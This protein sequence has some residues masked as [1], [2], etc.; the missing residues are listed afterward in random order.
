[1]LFLGS[2]LS[3]V[4]AC[5]GNQAS[6]RSIVS[7]FMKQFYPC[8]PEKDDAMA[9]NLALG[10]K[11]PGGY[12]K[13]K[14]MN[15]EVGEYPK[16]VKYFH[17][18]II[19]QIKENERGTVIQAI[20]LLIR[21]DRQI[22][23]DTVIDI[24]SETKKKD[25]FFC[26]ERIDS[27]LTGVFLYTLKN[28]S[29]KQE[30]GLAKKI[31]KK[32]V[33]RA[34][35]EELP[36]YQRKENKVL[37]KSLMD[38]SSI[39]LFNEEHFSSAGVAILLQGWNENNRFD[40][41]FIEILAGKNCL[42]IYEDLHTQNTINVSCENGIVRCV[43]ETQLRSKM[44]ENIDESHLRFL[45][46]AVYESMMKASIIDTEKS[47]T[48]N[49]TCAFL[50]FFGFNVMISN[51]IE[52]G[53]WDNIFF[54]FLSDILKEKRTIER[55]SPNLTTLV[56][57][58]PDVFLD[59]FEY[60]I[61]EPEYV[62]LDCLK[63]T[64]EKKI[65]C[66]LAYSL[67]K[68]AAYREYFAGAMNLLFELSSI[69]EVFVD[70]MRSVICFN[71][72]QTK[73]DLRTQIG[74][75]KNFFM[76]D[77]N[78]TWR[79]LRDLLPGYS[80]GVLMRIDFMYYPIQFQELS[81]TEVCQ[82]IDTYVELACSKIGK[83]IDRAIDLVRV[84]PILSASSANAVVDAILKE[85]LPSDNTGELFSL[86]EHYVK[87]LSFGVE[88][89]EALSRIQINFDS[90]HHDKQGV[91]AFKMRNSKKRDNSI[92]VKA[93]EYVSELY[94]KNGFEGLISGFK[95]VEDYTFYYEIILKILDKDELKNFS[96][97][98][99][100]RE[101]KGELILMLDTFS[102]EELVAIFDKTHPRYVE[103][104]CGHICDSFMMNYIQ[105]QR[106]E[107]ISTYWKN[108]SHVNIGDFDADQFAVLLEYLVKY[109]NY[110]LAFKILAIRIEY[111]DVKV[112][113]VLQVLKQ[114]DVSRWYADTGYDSER[115]Y[116]ILKTVMY[117]E[118]KAYDQNGLL[119][120]IEA[121]YIRFFQLGGTLKPKNVL[122]KMANTPQYVEEMIK[123]RNKKI[124]EKLYNSNE[125]LLLSWFKETPGCGKDGGV[126]YQKY[127]EWYE[128]AL[129]SSEKDEMLKILGEN[130]YHAVK[131]EN[132]A[133]FMN[134][135]VVEFI[136]Y[137]FDDKS[138]T[139]FECEALSSIGPVVLNSEL[140]IYEKF[141]KG[142][143]EK[144]EC[145]EKEGYIK[146][147][148]VFRSLSKVMA[149]RANKA[150]NI[151]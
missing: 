116:T 15:L 126:D 76:R 24:I 12:V 68:L 141:H 87:D 79:L 90:N 77:D 149:Y 147:S 59:V 63:D 125:S 105:T 84:C 80:R 117:V 99:M 101:L 122:L 78:M 5:K 11:N 144:A 21:D 2:L 51:R 71:Y 137:R 110:N 33:E 32:Y 66:S 146:T 70:N 31:A 127:C 119:S 43:I 61:R 48:L 151:K 103:L 124:Q 98:L 139:A 62:L 6:Q 29:N 114:Y 133:F 30:K 18:Y 91:D 121:K 113:Q 37:P 4:V 100:E 22:T 39:R 140:N 49:Q 16:I 129:N 106:Q 25:L 85:I 89:R 9:S 102:S 143:V 46:S 83:N 108:V 131:D 128:Y 69:S 94:K 40:K 112:E 88:Q 92:L 138:L 82:N 67:R 148:R 35:T 145:C 74:I 20:I 115:A 1:M 150:S 64:Y 75:M 130:S 57:A 135:K 23:D 13:D 47:T 26:P 54:E 136:E 53:K 27:F 142:F 65:L 44:V 97:Y 34:R 41:A 55:V 118:D 17:E 10:K 28:T 60:A 96:Y 120:D 56:E 36:I 123:S 42:D 19:P 81:E 45:L 52:S 111:D 107:M 86:A 72:P 109:M 73:A 38:T 14:V 58:N 3:I 134:R 7:A 95:T 132:D 104:L 8:Y 50:A 93:E